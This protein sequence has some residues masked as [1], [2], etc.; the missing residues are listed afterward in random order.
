MPVVSGV[1]R[2]TPLGRSLLPPAEDVQAERSPGQDERRRPGRAV[3]HA[4]APALAV[5]VR[6]VVAY[7]ALVKQNPAWHVP[8]FIVAVVLGQGVIRWVRSA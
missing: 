3:A 4:L 2:S 5:T 7:V 1:V 8:A 6:L